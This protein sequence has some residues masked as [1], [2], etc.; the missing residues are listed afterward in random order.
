MTN[1]HCVTA[2]ATLKDAPLNTPILEQG[3]PTQ[4]LWDAIYHYARCP[5][6]R[7]MGLAEIRGKSMSCEEAIMAAVEGRDL[8]YDTANGVCT[9]L[10]EVAAHEHIYGITPMKDIEGKP[11]CCN[12][13][14]VLAGLVDLGV[15]THPCAHKV[16]SQVRRIWM[17]APLSAHYDGDKEAAHGIEWTLTIAQEAGWDIDPLVQMA[18]V[19]KLGKF[20][21]L[22]L[23]A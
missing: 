16:C 3:R 22:L 19:A 20:Q 11:V 14:S 21:Q 10:R 23:P 15:D 6:C 9:T 8:L 5:D 18:P 1:V 12:P 17:D 7:P 13:R 4:E 2:R